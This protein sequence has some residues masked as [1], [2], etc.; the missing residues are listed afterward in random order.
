MGFAQVLSG[1]GLFSRAMRGSVVTAGAYAVSQALRLASNLILARL[2]Y[3][4]AFGIMALVSVALVGLAMFSDLGLGPAISQS[5]RGDDP[6]FLNTAWT[7]NALRGA[8]LWLM[9]CALALPMARLYQAPDLAWLLPAAGITLLISGFN[10]TRIDTANR[11]LLLGRVTAL[12]LASQVIGT[13]A[14]I[15]LSLSLRSV[16]ALVLG[17][18]AGSLAKL[19]LTWIFLPGQ[20]NRPRWEPAAARSLIH[21]GKWIFLSTACGF[22][23]SQGDKAIF[24]AWLTLPELGVYNIGW[25]LA[26]FPVL[27]AGSVISRIMI[28][29]YRDFPPAANA[30][31]FRRMRRLRF[32][33]T[34]LTICLLAVLGLIGVPLVH[35]LYDQRYAG[36]GAIIVAMACVQ[37]PGVIGMTYDQS[38]LAAGDSRNYFLVIALKAVIQTLSFLVGMSLGGLFGALAAQ[39]AALCVMHLPIIWLARRHHAWDGLH[40]LVFFAMA[41]LLC[42]VVLWHNQGVLPL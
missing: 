35:L 9:T 27:L 18:I 42:G 19:V 13:T 8:A 11:H 41:A 20:T 26:S 31:N 7:L 22:L 28:P 29:L 38:A 10:P 39:G 32:G 36:S 1:Q 2:L 23:L 30:A 14:M 33:A 25:F 37:M 16:W 17:A 34:G 5:P 12:D 4:E 3:P 15:A 40:D 21:F 24:G 6:D